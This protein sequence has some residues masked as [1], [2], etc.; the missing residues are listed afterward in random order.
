MTFSKSELRR[1]LMSQHL[2]MVHQWRDLFN[3]GKVKEALDPFDETWDVL[4]NN[5]VAAQ[6]YFAQHEDW[7]RLVAELIDS[8][9]PLLRQRANA[10]LQQE[11]ITIALNSSRQLKQSN[12]EYH[13]LDSLGNVMYDM[14][15]FDDAIEHYQIAIRHSETL[16]DTLFEARLLSHLG[17]AQRERGL[18][19]Q[20]QDSYERALAIAREHGDEPLQETCLR[21]IGIVLSR[22]DHGDEAVAQWEQALE[23]AEHIG[24][25]NAQRRSLGNLSSAYQNRGEF[26]QAEVCMKRSIELAQSTN[27]QRGHSQSLANRGFIKRKRGDLDG[28]LRDFEEARTVAIRAGLNLVAARQ[29]DN[30]A[31]INFA[32]GKI[33]EALEDA[34]DAYQVALNARAPREIG[35]HGLTYG[36]ILIAAARFA[37][38]VTVLT[39]AAEQPG[40]QATMQAL[41]A[42]GVSTVRMGDHARAVQIFQQV[43]EQSMNLIRQGSRQY[44]HWQNVGL[45]RA[46]LVLLDRCDPAEA[47][48]AYQEACRINRERGSIERQMILLDY[49]DP[50]HDMRL[51]PIRDLL[52]SHLTSE[53]SLKDI[54]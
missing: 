43:I 26:D 5:F 46:G 31:E 38:A 44:K 21:E 41:V 47:L 49:L 6:K 52:Q 9:S 3:Q 11:W 25:V 17:N 12:L 8:I 51:T 10:T 35:F 37:E 39:T 32:R 15:Q 48:A 33:A 53:T 27:D 36:W 34:Q 2:T 14:D 30:I 22:Q 29:D 16:G 40:G 19:T 28:A 54:D 20:A 23:L 7:Q 4:K 13:L 1:K 50:D 24:D 42:G 18:L 45:A